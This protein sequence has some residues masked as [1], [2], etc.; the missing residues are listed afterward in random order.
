MAEDNKEEP[1]PTENASANNASG[2]SSDSTSSSPTQEKSPASPAKE[3]D[4]DSLEF[5]PSEITEE[6][7]TETPKKKSPVGKLKSKLN[8]YLIVLISIMLMAGTIIAIALIQ[9]QSSSKNNKLKPQTLDQ[10]TLQQLA[11]ND[12]TVGSSQYIL[13]VVSNA[14]FAGQVLVRQGLEVAGNL[15]VG[16][17]AALNNVSVAGTGQFGQA[18]ITNNLSVGGNGAIQGSVTIAKSLQVTN[19]GSFGGAL[20]APQITTSNLQ[21]NGNL[22]LQHHISSSGSIPNRT[23]GTGLGNGGSVS[24]NGTDTAGSITVNTGS[25]TAVGCF[26]TVTFSTPFDT[27]PHIQVTPVGT[28]AAGVGFYINRSTTNFSICG[29]IPAPQGSTFGFDYFVID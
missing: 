4:D 10:S 15:K 1:K 16:G 29:T 20:T 11:N 19:G 17:T 25:S 2:V 22:V 14:I 12:A 27:I 21:L 7:K 26:I 28:G 8:I 3:V 5:N 18:T 23:G 9:S 6:D 24:I 13:N